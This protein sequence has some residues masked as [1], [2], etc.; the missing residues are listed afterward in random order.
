MPLD[1]VLVETAPNFVAHAGTGTGKRS[2]MDL[3]G[4]IE[5]VGV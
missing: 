2:S 5:V 4:S 3:S 1:V